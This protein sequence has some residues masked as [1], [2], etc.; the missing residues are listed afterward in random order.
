MQSPD[1]PVIN[2]KTIVAQLFWKKG[3][4]GHPSGIRVCVCVC[5]ILN[6]SVMF[7]LMMII[8]YLHSLTAVTL[9]STVFNF[10]RVSF[11]IQIVCKARL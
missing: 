6:H 5:V 4:C 3:N 1:L 8:L 10:F 7:R 9:C 11:K 2:V